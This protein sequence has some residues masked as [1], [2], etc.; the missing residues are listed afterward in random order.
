MQSGCAARW[1]TRS[2][3][4]PRSTASSPATASS[5]HPRG[6]RPRPRR[7]R[8]GRHLRGARSLASGAG[9]GADAGGDGSPLSFPMTRS[10]SGPSRRT[11]PRSPFT[12]AMA[13]GPTATEKMHPRSQAVAIRFRHPLT[14]AAPQQCPAMTVTFAEKLS[15]IPHYEPGTSSTTPRPARRPPTRSS[16][17]RTSRPSR[18]TRTW[19]MRSA[20]RRRRNRTPTPTLVRSGA[21]RRPPRD[22]P[23]PDRRLQRLLRD[24]AHRGSRAVRGGGRDP[25]RLALLLDLS[26]PARRSR[27]EGDPGTAGRGLP[28]RPRRDARGR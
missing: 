17:P 12:S 20:G 27:G 11:P 13:G 15:R 16:S 9:S 7:R 21:D 3:T 22:R 4:W 28:P 10:S 25:L 19:S 24:P 8:A 5:P 1:R 2:A 26:V 23:G 6:T 14:R 18:R